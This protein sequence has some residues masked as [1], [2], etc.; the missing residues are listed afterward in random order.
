MIT[1]EEFE[2]IELRAGSQIVC[3]LFI[4]ELLSTS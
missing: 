3:K 4:D 2:K 1:I